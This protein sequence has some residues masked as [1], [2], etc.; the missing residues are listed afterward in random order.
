MSKRKLV[1]RPECRIAYYV[2]VAVLFVFFIIFTQSF[3]ANP[4]MAMQAMIVWIVFAFIF[5]TV[6]T[7]LTTRGKMCVYVVEEE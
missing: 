1:V 4:S 5:F 2:M 3:L 6:G 7:Y